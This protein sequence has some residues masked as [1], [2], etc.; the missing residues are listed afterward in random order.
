MTLHRI[1]L[2]RPLRAAWPSLSLPS[3]I[4][5][6]L[7]GGEVGGVNKKSLKELIVV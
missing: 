6:R 3:R 7:S 5:F 4:L 1:R 2:E